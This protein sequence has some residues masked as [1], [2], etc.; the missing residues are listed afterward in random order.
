MNTPQRHHSATT[1]QDH[2]HITEPQQLQR[3][4][5][6]VNGNSHCPEL[7][8]EEPLQHQHFTLSEALIPNIRLI[9]CLIAATR[10]NFSEKTPSTIT[11]EAD[12]FAAR[13]LL[14]GVRVFHLDITLIPMLKTANQRA[15]AF[16]RQHQLP[17]SP[18]QMRMSLHAA[19]PQP[20]LIL[21]TET[22]FEDQGMVQNSLHI[23]RHSQGIIQP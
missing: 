17:F 3:W 2:G 1:K 19:R 12:W 15:Q 7:C 18:A 20:L 10:L 14:L 23:A 9:A 11:E 21:E 13:I 4:Y 16:A 22:D 8:P 6:L 5:M